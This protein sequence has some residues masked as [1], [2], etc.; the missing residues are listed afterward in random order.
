MSLP[1][2]ADMVR[3]I[4]TRPSKRGKGLETTWL[5]LGRPSPAVQASAVSVPIVAGFGND[6]RA[7]FI[8]YCENWTSGIRALVLPAGLE[9]L[10]VLTLLL[11]LPW[12]EIPPQGDERSVE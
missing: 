8:I 6:V 11:A 3:I 1:T 7:Q 9:P 5:P 10:M 12:S 4:F 2:T